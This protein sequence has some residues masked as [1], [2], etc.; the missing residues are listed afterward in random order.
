[1]VFGFPPGREAMPLTEWLSILHP[2][3][4]PRV[5]A[6]RAA[7]L[8]RGEA[9]QRYEFRILRPDTGALRHVELRSRREYDADGRPLRSHGVAFD[10]TETRL[11]EA[12]QRENEERLRLAQD[13]AGIGIWDWDVASRALCWSPR[14]NELHGIPPDRLQVTYG[15]WRAAVHP[16]DLPATVAAVAAALDGADHYVAEYRVRLPDIGQ[17]WL[18][19]RGVVLRDADGRAARMI[20]VTIDVTAAKT[21]E[22]A[23][24]RDNAELESRV[25][26]RTRALTEAAA[27]LRAEMQ[28]RD[29]AQGA[30]VQA[31]KLEALGQLT[32]SVA[33]DFNNVLAAVMGSM[34]LISRR[35]TG[36]AQIIELARNGER[37]AERAAA[38]V[39]QLL[40]FARREDLLPVL[41]DPAA[42]LANTDEMLRR[43]VGSGITLTV[44]AAEVWPV[45]ADPHRLEVALLNLAMNARD[46][47]QGTGRLR[48]TAR[49]VLAAAGARPPG[50]SG[51]DH[52][53][54]A[55]QDSGV[56]MPVEVL[57]RAA[58]PFFTTKPRGKGTGLGLS[59]VHGFAQQSGGGLQ[60]QSAPG[61]GTTVEIWLPRA[62]PGDAATP[63]QPQAEPDPSLH[64][65]ATLLVVD[66]DD[67]VRL[68]NASQ[69]R[70]LGYAVLEASSVASGM[71][72]ALAAE[73]LDLVVTDVTMPG[74]NGQELARRLRAARPGV[75]ILFLTG[76]D[77]RQSLQGE[78][79]LGKPFSIAELG[80][81]V[82]ATLGRLP[83]PLHDRML[84]RLGRSKL[85]E[86]YFLWRSR[87]DALD[88]AAP[89]AA[90][91]PWFDAAEVAALSGAPHTYLLAVELAGEAP[92][93]LRFQWVGAALAARPGGML[94]GR[95]VDAEI[96]AD[97]VFGGLAAALQRCTR[98]GVP[99][100]D[101]ARYGFQDGGEPVY[102]ERI[103][104]PLAADQEQRPTH[105]LGIALFSGPI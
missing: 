7:S 62:A 18:Q 95:L 75:P 101:Y 20:G 57:A 30:L 78:V 11:A 42:L 84:M 91:L 12:A 47:M 104:L 45:L 51:A 8:G 3:D 28:R 87:R 97:E 48:V 40:A 81:Q 92:P 71:V 39:R 26:E 68:V 13:A 15:T 99:C 23:L 2:E 90:A 100:H 88:R 50:L 22:A 74:G 69:L 55:V 21:A 102:F 36:N 58:E 61:A 98:L 103:L 4:R 56:G 80:R 29:E 96:E 31:Q 1:M 49:N 27:E 76:F 86:A 35:A 54:F 33:H 34:R 25:A 60:L 65:A 66:D 17:R 64:G 73:R 53:V 41:V 43:A 46:A 70:E 6:Q 82:L 24:A 5:A 89:G 37:A 32:G 94:E 44:E 19:A 83:A 16:D 67:Q 63:G 93:R 10:V 77:D 52:V 14:N 79:V 59:M 9:G 72:Q 105:L 38:L 85:R